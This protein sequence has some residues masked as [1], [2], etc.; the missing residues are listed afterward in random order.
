MAFPAFDK[1]EL[2]AAD[3]I[4][5][6]AYPRFGF[7]VPELFYPKSYDNSL[8]CPKCYSRS[9]QKVPFRLAKQ[10]KETGLFAFE[11][12][13]L[14]AVF[15]SRQF[16]DLIFAKLPGAFCWPVQGPKSSICDNVVQLDTTVLT[17]FELGPRDIWHICPV[18]E[19]PT[20][21]P[22]P[23]SAFYKPK[24]NGFAFAKGCELMNF[25]GRMI[26]APFIFSQDL[27]RD[28]LKHKV[29]GLLFQPCRKK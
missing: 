25:G 2:L 11:L 14:N 29:K 10:P 9:I 8:R 12:H 4:R 7:P 26:Y 3:Y 22:A 17:E 23:T 18:C 20:Y 21:R 1:D 16:W 28:L 13:T 5:M 6:W 27:Y 24:L 15:L 19:I